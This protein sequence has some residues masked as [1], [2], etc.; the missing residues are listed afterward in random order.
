ME[1]T[2]AGS[3]V[4]NPVAS[5]LHEGEHHDVPHASPAIAEILQQFNVWPEIKIMGDTTIRNP[6]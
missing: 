3:L 6:L 2:G 1:G 5:A 4:Y